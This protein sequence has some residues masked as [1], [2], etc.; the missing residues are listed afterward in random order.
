MGDSM[1][2]EFSVEGRSYAVS[3]QV[4]DGL[5][6]VVV[7]EIDPQEDVQLEPEDE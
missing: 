3:T 6:I 5:A 4:G 2:F 1:N 7:Q